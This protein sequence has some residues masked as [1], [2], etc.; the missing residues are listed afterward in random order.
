[1]LKKP[2]YTDLGPTFLEDSLPS[3][4]RRSRVPYVFQALGYSIPDEIYSI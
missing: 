4:D 3:L 1:M 2:L